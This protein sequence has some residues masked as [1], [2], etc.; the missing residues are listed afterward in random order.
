M[1]WRV[2]VEVRDGRPIVVPILRLLEP[3]EL[4]K[5]AWATSLAVAAIA[6]AAVDTRRRRLR[7]H[8]SFG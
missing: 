6:I 2:S 7:V 1:M 8:Q 4:S 3:N 5:Y